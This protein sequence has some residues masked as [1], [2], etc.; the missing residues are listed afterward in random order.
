MHD[1]TTTERLNLPS[2]KDLCDLTIIVDRSGSMRHISDDMSKGLHR[3]IDAQRLVRGECIASLTSFSNGVTKHFVAQP[4]NSVPAIELVP[5]GG[6]ALMDAVGETIMDVHSRLA[7]LPVGEL[8]QYVTIIIITDGF[9]NASHVFVTEQVR[10]MIAHQ[11]NTYGWQFLF[12]GTK[13]INGA[14]LLGIPPDHA[15]TWT[16]SRN[17]AESLFERLI[18]A[19]KQLRLT[20]TVNLLPEHE[21]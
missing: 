1:L 7:A 10:Q 9:E 15:S 4:S 19:T 12:I 14:R 2:R 18:D 16:A 21:E 17:G 3:F 20:G 6:T 5:Y 8:P 13:N 11:T